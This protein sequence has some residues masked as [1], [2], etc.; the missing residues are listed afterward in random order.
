M[1]NLVHV[2]SIEKVNSEKLTPIRII[3]KA[4]CHFNAEVN[5]EE[6]KV[7][8]LVG[9]TIEDAYENNQK[10]YTVTAQ[11]LMKDKEPLTDRHLSFKLTSIN[12]KQYLLG[13]N[14]RPFP[15]IKENNNFPEKPADSQMKQVT[16]TW[17]ST[18]SLLQIV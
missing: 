11:F 5:F 4:K 18:Y 7:Q 12:G 3:S 13:T 1:S 8:E 17:K 6:I 15:I 2:V 14:S 10:I 16:I 9:V